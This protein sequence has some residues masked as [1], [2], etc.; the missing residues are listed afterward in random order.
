M[1]Y[2]VFMSYARKDGM[3]LA[4]K[5]AERL[6]ET[7]LQVFWDQD[8]IPAGSNWE[9]KLDEALEQANHILVVLTPA[10]V[11]SEEVTAEWRP[12]L[13]RGKNIIP[14]MYLD[15][16]IPRRLSMRQYID[17]RNESRQV[18]AFA[19]L[20]DAINTFS[21]KH[22]EL[23]LSGRELLQRAETNRKLNQIDLA[24]EDYALTL[25]DKDKWVRA[26]TV[27]ILTQE[28]IRRALSQLV[29]AVSEE[30]AIWIKMRLLRAIS[31]Y[32]DNQDYWRTT[33]PDFID[34]LKPNLLSDDEE[35]RQETIRIFAY[36][37]AIETAPQI[38]QLLKN[39]PSPIVRA[40]AALALGRLKTPNGIQALLGALQ[41]QTRTRASLP[42]K[43]LVSMR[44][45]MSLV[46]CK[47]LSTK[48]AR[49]KCETPPTKS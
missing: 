16:E 41:T 40:Q 17:F 36:G 18:I 4:Q 34:Q 15:C 2:D 8:S 3:L 29:R 37:Q 22:V 31:L 11:I 21:P 43:R 12:M 33:V 45:P 47:Q 48:I 44:M 28:P 13:S 25:R 38:I 19:E 1:T 46:I 26:D 39:D 10:S 20:I 14:L 5:V 23:E 7:G 9:Q 27:E 35:V 49:P 6:R 32:I 30:S 24:L 42:S